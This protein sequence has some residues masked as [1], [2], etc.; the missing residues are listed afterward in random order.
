[1]SFQPSPIRPGVLLQ[2]DPGW[3]APADGADDATREPIRDMLWDRCRNSLGIARLLVSEGRPDALVATACQ[4]AAEAACRSALE[5]AGFPFDGDVARGLDRL[6]APPE[7]WL[8]L[9]SAP[10]PRRLAAAERLV[11]WIAGYLRCQVPERSWGY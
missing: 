9:S 4:M 2:D 5:H 1:V 7:L 6:S 10:P 11:A 8:E 3:R